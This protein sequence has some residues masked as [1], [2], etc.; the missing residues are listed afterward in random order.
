MQRFA[1]KNTEISDMFNM[2]KSNKI[3]N[4][5]TLTLVLDPEVYNKLQ[6]LYMELSN[7]V[8]MMSQAY[9]L[10]E[11]YSDSVKQIQMTVYQEAQTLYNIY[12]TMPS[13]VIST[14]LIV[15][16]SSANLSSLNDPAVITETKDAITSLLTAMPTATQKIASYE[17]ILT[18][19]FNA[20]LQNTSNLDQISQF[21]GV[22]TKYKA[23]IDLQL[24]SYTNSVSANQVLDKTNVSIV[25]TFNNALKLISSVNKYLSN[26]SKQLKAQPPSAINASL[27][28]LIQT[29]DSAV[30]GYESRKNYITG[31]MQT[32]S[33]PLKEKFQSYQNPYNQP[34]LSDNKA[35]SLGRLVDADKVKES[36]QSYENPYNAPSLAQS[37]EFRLGKRGLIDEVS[38]FMK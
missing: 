6:V 22:F 12:V 33:I 8:D 29:L 23:L 9:S 32:N 14:N 16:S 20:I 26:M 3:A 30:D 18:T 4:D 15:N 2:I 28:T 31:I 25:N 38:A 35:F 27:Q 7:Y 13:T 11:K 17:Q 36:F 37:K 5:K 10:T 1:L 34:S 24:Q 21:N 19:N